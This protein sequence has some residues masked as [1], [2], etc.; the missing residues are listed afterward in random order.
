[1]QTM[2]NNENKS[3]YAGM[4]IIYMIYKG[5]TTFSGMPKTDAGFGVTVRMAQRLDLYLL[6]G[7][8]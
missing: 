4:Q 8:S 1:M 5:D 7:I 6:F 3:I 2:H